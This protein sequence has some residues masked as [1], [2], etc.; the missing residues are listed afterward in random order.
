M[1]CPLKNIILANNEKWTNHVLFS[2]LISTPALDCRLLVPTT[3][4]KNWWKKLFALKLLRNYCNIK[5]KS[6]TSPLLFRPTG[7]SF[8]KFSSAFIVYILGWFTFQGLLPIINLPIIKF[9][10]WRM[11][12]HSW[13]HPRD[14][15]GGTPLLT[16]LDLQEKKYIHCSFW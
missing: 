1:E 16:Y 9:V 4:T 14:W 10:V 15:R 11:K 13:F 5:S 2:D 8:G 6:R 3:T 12:L 7:F